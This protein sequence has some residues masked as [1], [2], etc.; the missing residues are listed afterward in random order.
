MRHFIGLVNIEGSAEMYR[1]R[2]DVSVNEM[3]V[4]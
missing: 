1:P 2:S 4:A 3:G